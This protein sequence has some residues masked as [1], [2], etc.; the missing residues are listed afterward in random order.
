MT[1]ATETVTIVMSERVSHEITLTHARLAQLLAIAVSDVPALL[2]DESRWS[3]SYGPGGAENTAL[4]EVIDQ[5]PNWDSAEDRQW[6][7]R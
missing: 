1:S 6:S 7:I 4:L 5:E 2:A 3:P